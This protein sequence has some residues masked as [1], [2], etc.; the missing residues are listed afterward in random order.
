MKKLAAPHQ[1][2][3]DHILWL[4]VGLFLLVNGFVGVFG[5]VKYSADG[6]DREM[7]LTVTLLSVVAFFGSIFCFY[8]FIKKL[9]K[10]KDSS[11]DSH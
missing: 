5:I 10:Y 8:K 9:K 6:E 1:D 11:N 3:L 2:P 7:I 4:I